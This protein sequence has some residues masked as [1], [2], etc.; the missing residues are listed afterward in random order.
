MITAP[1][2][3]LPHSFERPEDF[4]SPTQRFDLIADLL[5]GIALRAEEEAD[6]PENA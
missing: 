6:G 3:E 2:D 1:F 4:L 5:A